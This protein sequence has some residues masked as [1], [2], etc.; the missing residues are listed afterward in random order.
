MSILNRIFWKRHYLYLEKQQL[1]GVLF[2]KHNP[3]SECV[4]YSHVE[5]V[6][7]DNGYSNFSNLNY[8][9]NG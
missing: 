1:I 5:Y 7:Y 6:A 3:I 9:I 8:L 4:Q 2:I